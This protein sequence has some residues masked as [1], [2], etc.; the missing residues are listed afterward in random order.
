MKRPLFFLALFSFP[1]WVFSQETEIILPTQKGPSIVP[2]SEP[3]SGTFRRLR[4]GMSLEE[5]KEALAADELFAFRGDP[6]VSFLPVKE[7][8]LVETAGLSFIRR[9]FFQLREGRVFIMAFRLDPQR[10]DH[11]SVFTSLVRK[12]GEPASLNPQEAVWENGEIRVSLE[13]PLTVKYLDMTVF[14]AILGEARA[15]ESAEI[16]RRQGFLNDF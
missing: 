12:Y 4:L 9:A 11:Y 15:E 2:G 16:F 8:N 5:L 13:R 14:R 10:M 1:L 3:L 7:E 6:D